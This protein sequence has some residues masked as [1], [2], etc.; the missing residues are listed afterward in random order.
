MKRAVLLA[1]SGSLL[2]CAH[3]V[4]AQRSSPSAPSDSIA[5]VW[6]READY[7][8]FVKA[9]DVNSYVSLWHD[10]FIGWPCGQEH[11]KR[12]E[13]IGEWVQEVRDK[14]ISVT[15]DLTREGA[16]AFGS[17]VV[18]HYRFS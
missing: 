13:S 18:V 16:E 12:K 10:K 4:N 15:S 9:G 11:P 5:Q 1:L 14:H 6:G 3:L 8:R 17:I 7:W 2:L